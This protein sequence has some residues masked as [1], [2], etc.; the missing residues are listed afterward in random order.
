MRA[1]VVENCLRKI[2]LKAQNLQLQF[3]VQKRSWKIHLCNKL[4]FGFEKVG[5]KVGLLDAD[6]YGPSIKN[7]EIDEKPKSDKK[8]RTY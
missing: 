4:G 8:I 5:C 7:A 1:K 2:R 3:Q 6:I